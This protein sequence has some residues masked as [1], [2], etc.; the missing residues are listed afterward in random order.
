MKI[1]D[2]EMENSEVYKP[3]TQSG[4]DHVTSLSD[5]PGPRIT[6]T[7]ILDTTDENAK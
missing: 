1:E 3:R 2:F 5:I 6:K 4:T 7:M